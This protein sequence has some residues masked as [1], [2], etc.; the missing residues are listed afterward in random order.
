MMPHFPVSS[1]RDIPLAAGIGLR[2]PHKREILDEKPAIAWLEVHSENYFGGGL[3]VRMLEEIR[4]D[5]PL[6]FHGVA[7]SLGSCDGLSTDHLKSLKTIVD[8]FEPGLVSEHVSWSE[9]H[10]THLNDLL[11]LPYTQE[12]LDIVCRNIHHMQDFLG[13]QILVENPSTY[14]E[15]KHST[16]PEADFMVEVA[17]RTGC[18]LLLDVN[19]IFVSAQ[20]H[21]LDAFDYIRKIPPALV[22]EIHLAGH[23]EI[24]VNS[25]AS[26]LID[27]HGSKVKNDV[28]GLFEFTLQQTG[29]VPVL[30]EWD[31]DVPDLQ[32][33]LAE[34]TTAQR[35]LDNLPARA[36]EKRYAA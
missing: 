8:R 12:A 6:S 15:Y 4:V 2:G 24:K 23:S 1:G 35:Y 18:K 29:R 27:D 33:L 28:W 36:K 9:V 22:G 34:A 26:I 11:P 25:R 3:P 10:G 19:N 20:N 7:L 21:N 17:T 30:V 5:Y 13:R 32:T 16:I 14:L 31:T